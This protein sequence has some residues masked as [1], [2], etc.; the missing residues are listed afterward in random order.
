MASSSHGI[1]ANKDD[2]VLEAKTE[3]MQAMG[4]KWPTYL[5]YMNFYFRQ[6]WT[7]KELDSE[8]MKLLPPNK[9]RLHNLYFRSIL[10]KIGAINKPMP[11]PAVTMETTPTKSGTTAGS[12]S[13]R[14][15]KRSTKLVKERTTFETTDL[16]EFLIEEM[17]ELT[18]PNADSSPPAVPCRYLQQ[19]LFLP[20]S[21]LILGRFVVAAWELGLV[22]V[23]TNVAELIIQAVQVISN[24]ICL[25]QSCF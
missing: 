16:A 17:A 6:K 1:Q 22:N 3:L 20:D 14:K 5:S 11:T 19:E 13:S 7:K 18:K 23:D 8:A 9:V 10:I 4:D 21:S 24:Y 12:G 2:K 15:R 25:F